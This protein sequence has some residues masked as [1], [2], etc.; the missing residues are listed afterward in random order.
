VCI[1]DR[2]RAPLL[3][4]LMAIAVTSITG[5]SASMSAKLRTKSITRFARSA[6]VCVDAGV[7]QR[8]SKIPQLIIS[9]IRRARPGDGRRIDHP[10]P[11]CPKRGSGAVASGPTREPCSRTFGQTGASSSSVSWVAQALPLA[12]MHEQMR[13]LVVKMLKLMWR[14]GI[15]PRILNPCFVGYSLVPEARPRV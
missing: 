1:G 4:S 5:D 15:M 14:Q 2:K 12:V 7:I 8:L 9:P 6:T 10:V 11:L 13:R 3:S